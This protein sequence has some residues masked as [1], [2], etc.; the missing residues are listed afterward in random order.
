MVILSN[1]NWSCQLYNQQWV[2][3]LQ[4]K[5]WLISHRL[6]GSLFWQNKG[7][8]EKY[9]QWQNDIPSHYYGIKL[10]HNSLST[11][12]LSLHVLFIMRNI[13]SPV[14]LL[15]FIKCGYENEIDCRW[16][17]SNEKHTEKISH[18]MEK[19]LI[20]LYLNIEILFI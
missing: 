14:E 8:K 19:S 11:F 9:F 10:A 17:K 15:N 2:K 20:K 13:N 3:H 12:L 7:N 6:D 16:I 5:H 4:R 18:P 1:S